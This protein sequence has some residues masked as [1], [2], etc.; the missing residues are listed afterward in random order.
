M[1]QYAHGHRC[2]VMHQQRSRLALATFLKLPCSRIQTTVHRTTDCNSARLKVGITHQNANE[3][4][5]G[6]PLPY[7]TLCREDQCAET[8]NNHKNCGDKTNSEEKI[9][10]RTTAEVFT[11]PRSYQVTQLVQRCTHKLT[12]LNKRC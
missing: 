6:A 11:G 1:K 10:E 3:V 9:G 5:F 4:T 8:I 2:L 12:V 7:K